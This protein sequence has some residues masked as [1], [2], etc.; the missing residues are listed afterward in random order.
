MAHLN[1]KQHKFSLRYKIK[2]ISNNQ[3]LWIL[4]KIST[5]SKYIIHW[6]IRNYVPTFPHLVCTDCS[7]PS[8]QLLWSLLILLTAKGYLVCYNTLSKWPTIHSFSTTACP[9]MTA[10]TDYTLVTELWFWCKATLSSHITPQCEYC[11]SK[12]QELLIVSTHV[13]QVHLL[14][15]EQ[16]TIH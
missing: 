4:I 14:C 13:L 2:M 8:Y 11:H 9:I 1:G 5:H 7:H 3:V 15:R 16:K 12:Y 10:V 6:S